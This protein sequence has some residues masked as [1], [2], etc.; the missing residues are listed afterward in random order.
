MEMRNLKVSEIAGYSG[1]GSTNYFIEA[2]KKFYGITPGKF[3]KLFFGIIV[4]GK[5][6]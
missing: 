1:W 3:K 2:F 4:P 5:E 6:W